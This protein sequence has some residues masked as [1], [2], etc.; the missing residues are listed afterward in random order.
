MNEL[1]SRMNWV[2]FSH[3]P[4]IYFFLKN[5]QHMMYIQYLF[6]SFDEQN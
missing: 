3:L 4:R 6:L 5:Q 1:N 2:E